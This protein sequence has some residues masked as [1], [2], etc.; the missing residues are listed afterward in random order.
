MARLDTILN[1]VSAEQ[2]DGLRLLAGS[3]PQLIF[4]E[5]SGAMKLPPFTEKQLRDFVMELTTQGD[6]ARLHADGFLELHYDYQGAL[7]SCV[8]QSKQAGSFAVE[9]TVLDPA[10]FDGEYEEELSWEARKSIEPEVSVA[11]PF[12]PLGVDD[13][14]LAPVSNSGPSMSMPRDTARGGTRP[15]IAIHYTREEATAPPVFGDHLSH[16]EFAKLLMWMVEQDA[17]DLH[18]TPRFPPTL[19]VDNVFQPSQARAISDKE[20]ERLLVNI[21]SNRERAEL[22]ANNSVDL[23]YQVEGLGRFRINVFR[24]LHGL[25]AAIRLIRG[26]VDSLSALNLPEELSW[27]TEQHTGLVLFTGPTGSG[28]STTMAALI[29]QMNQ[30]RQLHILTLE[31]PVEYLFENQK[32]LIQQR[33]VPTHTATFEQGL[34]DALRE[35]PDVIMVGE[36]RDYETVQMALS[37]SETG[38][39]ILATMHAATTNNAI[40]RLIDVFPDSLKDGARAMISD[41]LTGVVNLR[42]LTHA[43]GRGLVPAVEFLKNNH[44]VAA[45]IREGK[46]HQLRQVLSTS[47]SEGMW[48][49]ERYLVNLFLKN[50]ITRDD[51][52][53]ASP[54]KRAFEQLLETQRKHRRA[55]K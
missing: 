17:T 26:A 29:E 21:L 42:L 36:L 49:F 19:R 44:A 34:R 43:S 54:D 32:C 10:G 39:L 28:K 41:T 52:Y 23:S 51:A 48:P 38:H 22:E 31:A 24:Q 27:L 45:T 15:S 20:L 18:L 55:K 7:F 37:A 3:P 25:S 1:A 13:G 16:E 5:T 14:G 8:I 35:N 11:P 4:G 47:S 30:N 6:L 9:F 40:S 2:A 12:R 53:R 46:M 50:Q 33:E